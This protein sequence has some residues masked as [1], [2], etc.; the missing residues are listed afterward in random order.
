MSRKIDERRQIAELHAKYVQ[1]A[2]QFEQAYKKI[3][4]DD[5]DDE[6]V[7]SEDEEIELTDEEIER[8]VVEASKLLRRQDVPAPPPAP[9]AGTKDNPDS[10]VDI[11][12][13]CENDYYL[14]LRLTPWQ[15]LI[16]KTFYM[17]TAGN[18]HLTIGEQRPDNG[19]VG[20]VWS[21]N[22]EC[23]MEHAK[24]RKFKGYKTKLRVVG[25]ENSPCLFCTRFD[26]EIRKRPF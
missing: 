24:T 21:K 25:P 26:P 22:L 3:Q 16:L 14:G 13:F 8:Q 6:D 2:A 11:I 20:C 5:D 9:G 10:I 15:E 17:G 1:S 19:C 7:L 12:T 23:E 4:D 18:S